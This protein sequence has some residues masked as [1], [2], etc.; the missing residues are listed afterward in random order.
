MADITT[1]SVVSEYSSE[2]ALALRENNIDFKTLEDEKF[3][4]LTGSS[5]G[6]IYVLYCL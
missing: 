5:S 3:D 6:T 2:L 4:A 1:K